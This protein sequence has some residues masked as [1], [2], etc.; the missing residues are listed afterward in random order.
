MT[1]P[2]PEEVLDSM[3]A[4][5]REA[6]RS[7]GV[8][9]LKKGMRRDAVQQALAAAMGEVAKLKADL[10]AANKAIS[11]EEAEEGEGGEAG[12]TEPAPEEVL[13]S[14]R[15]I[16][17]EALRSIGVSGL[18]KGMRRDAVRAL[19][20]TALDKRAD[21]RAEEIARVRLDAAKYLTA[22]ECKGKSI[23][24]LRKAVVTKLVPEV[25][26]DS[27]DGK[28]I[29]TMF[30]TAVKVAPVKQADAAR[31]DSSRSNA[32]INAVLN[33]P[34]TDG[35]DRSL[36]ALYQKQRDEAENRWRGQPNG[37]ASK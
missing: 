31:N 36:D 20:T 3:R 27:I 24:E 34:R 33:K 7:M 25:K 4:V 14:M 12:M 9:G 18:K 16:R 29:A 30:D 5:R 8:A 15:A 6:F 37:S 21:A 32:D 2:A 28:T 23:D 26:L 13:D 22:D 35:E 19:I 1:E 17:R 11:T 10:D